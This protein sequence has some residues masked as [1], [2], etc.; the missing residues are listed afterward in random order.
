MRDLLPLLDA[1]REAAAVGNVV[2][3]AH[4]HLAAL[5]GASR[6]ERRL[7]H[8]E[9]R[10][11]VEA[12]G[13]ELSRGERALLTA[14]L[15]E[16]DRGPFAAER[17]ALVQALARTDRPE[18]PP[19]PGRVN[20]LFVSSA[21]VDGR[22]FGIVQPVDILVEP[23]GE[24]VILEHAADDE[25][26][27]AGFQQAVWAAQQFLLAGSGP[28]APRAGFPV[29]IRG[30]LPR[31]PR[32]LPVTGPSIGLAA[33]VGVISHFLDRPVPSSVAF[34][35]RVDPKGRLHPVGGLATKLE[36]AMQKGIRRVFV[37]RDSA[38][39]APPTPGTAMEVIPSADLPAVVTA[40]F[41]QALG[42]RVETGA[43]PPGLGSGWGIDRSARWLLTFVGKAD[44]WGQYL[45]HERHGIPRHVQEEGPILTLCRVL[46]P[47]GVTLLHTVTGPDN[48]F[49]DRAMAV[50][51]FLGAAD[52][53]RRIVQ[54]PLSVADPTDYGELL[55]AMRQAVAAA[56][57]AA[58]AGAA[59]FANLSSGSPQMETSW[60]L[61]RAG[62]GL[63][64]RLLQVREGRFMPAGQS[65]VRE[66]ELPAPPR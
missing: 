30:V 51:R 59:F 13:P 48:D 56:M 3:A 4:H 44:P 23:G 63:P 58:P 62:G 8:G 50:A 33:A 21:L 40:V 64:L 1:C 14:W 46:D 35:G 31:I 66:V 12:Y 2:L 25:A 7:L 43:V 28:A 47:A 27:F 16:T 5:A 45:D 17:A 55:P 37:P 38:G 52:P 61:L 24:R 6:L 20:A 11:L 53:G 18:S 34:T 29:T 54:A 15:G 36:A 10:A 9:L 49:R 65:R 42:T 32:A 39:E 22:R 26:V 41:G 57:A 60:H 19:P